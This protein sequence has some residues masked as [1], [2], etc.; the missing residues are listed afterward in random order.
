M[1]KDI[2]NPSIGLVKAQEVG[3]SVDPYETAMQSPVTPVSAESFMAL[4]DPVIKRDANALDATSKTSLQRH[5][6]KLGKAAQIL[7]AKGG[8]QQDQI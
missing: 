7:F 2:T 5:M 6:Q 1:L 4:Q 3:V 8:L